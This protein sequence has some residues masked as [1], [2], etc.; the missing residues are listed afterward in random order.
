[1]LYA[2]DTGKKITKLPHKSDYVKWRKRISTDDY[3]RVVARIRAT[4]EG[5]EVN[6]S[7]IHI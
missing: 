3:A 6:L 2:V 1:M 7:L 5:N 4:T